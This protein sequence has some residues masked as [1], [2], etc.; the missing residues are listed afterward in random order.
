[1]AKFYKYLAFVLSVAVLKLQS[2]RDTTAQGVAKVRHCESILEDP[3]E[4]LYEDP[5]AHHMYFGSFAQTWM[6][7]RVTRAVFDLLMVGMFDML[8][9][10]TKWIDDQILEWADGAEQLVILGAGYDTRGFRLDL[11]EGFNVIEVDQP[12]VQSRKRAILEGLSSDDE[13]VAAKLESGVEFVPIDFNHDSVGNVLGSKAKTSFDSAKKT[14]VTLEGVS[15]YIPKGAT[16]STLKQLHAI[17]P[18]ES[19]LIISYVDDALFTNPSE[20]GD[21]TRIHWML[22]VVEWFGEPWITSWNPASFAAFLEKCGFAVIDDV[23]VS[24]LNQKYLVPRNRGRPKEELA[25][26]ERYVV[27]SVVK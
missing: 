6:G 3:S 20:Y 16:E 7:G 4:R 14:I 13:A 22:K 8:S 9:L 26:M 12:G 27:A 17:V 11:P 15:Q 2:G 25:S 10:R 18:E 19:T 5:Y 23:S 24:D 21:P 1:M